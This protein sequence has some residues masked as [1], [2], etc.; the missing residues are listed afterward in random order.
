MSDVSE[1]K[2]N[3]KRGNTQINRALAFLTV[4]DAKTKKYRCKICKNELSG[5]QSTN[6]V[7]H[8]KTDRPNH[9][10]IYYNEILEAKQ[11]HVFVQREEFLFSAVELCTI[12]SEP[13]AVLSK[14]GYRNGHKRQLELFKSA[15]CP[16]NLSDE[17]LC[18][19]KEKVHT[20]AK[21]IK[22]QI[23]SETHNKI[24]SV[25]VNSATRNGRSIY[26]ISLQYK[27][28]GVVKVVAIGMRELKKS[29][30]AEY[31]AEVLIEVLSEYEITLE[32]VISITTDNG[33]NMLAM[34]KE[35][36]D[37]LF[38]LRGDSSTQPSESEKQCEQSQTQSAEP[39]ENDDSID[40]DI[41]HLLKTTMDEDALDELLG[42]VDFYENL[43]EKLVAKLR[44]ETGNQ[45]LFVNS[46]KCAVHTIQ[47][48]VK[49]ALKFLS[50]QDQNVVDLC[51][52][53][54]KFLRKQ[55]TQNE[56]RE[57]GLTSILPCLD[58]KTRWSST[59]LLIQSILKLMLQKKDFT[60]SDFNGLLKMMDMKLNQFKSDPCRYTKLADA[61]QSCLDQRK[62]P[63]IT[64]SL[65]RCALFLDPRYKCDID[66]DKE[67]VVFV[68][69]TLANIW[70]RI[71]SVKNCEETNEV[72]TQVE[73]QS[74][75]SY[76]INDLYEEL[77]EEYAAQNHTQSDQDLDLSKDKSEIEFA[78]HKYEQSVA[79]FGER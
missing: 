68:K 52:L 53:V 25:M 13:F 24:V 5:K 63:L 8:F 40:K 73:I 10:E 1:E 38:K 78:I 71:K 6:L 65:M 54:A 31:L 56:M 30:T 60:L 44:N 29:H 9:K 15:G 70:Q 57:E 19:I 11:P 61:L 14:S 12:N 28:N 26:G 47:L 51:R 79:V 55:S 35:V 2:E 43:F 21:Q 45:S 4:V 42:D 75:S 46:I 62:K 18:E 77:D 64:N 76:G 48:A 34:V 72:A 59:Y 37:I 32:Q 58:V 67:L 3:T 36:E 7:A 41:D 39:S 49:D 33:S 74:K 50:T 22:E 17:H 20:T 27:Q 16:V 23:K 66:S 69:L